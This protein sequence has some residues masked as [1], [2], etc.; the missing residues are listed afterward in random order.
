MV[1]D[2]L[3]NDLGIGTNFASSISHRTHIPSAYDKREYASLCIQGILRGPPDIIISELNVF[4]PGKH[5]VL[6][7]TIH[8]V[9]GHS[10][11]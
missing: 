2:S 8:T 11:R 5:R 4:R 1:Q 3:S 6:V 7:S 9:P 10:Q